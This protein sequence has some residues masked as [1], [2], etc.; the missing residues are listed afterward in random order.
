LSF[1]NFSRLNPA[2]MRLGCRKNLTV[3]WTSVKRRQ[4][5]YLENHR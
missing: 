4:R 2:G 3:Y 5:L 1:S